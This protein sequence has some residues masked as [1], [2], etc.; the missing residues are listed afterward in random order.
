MSLGDWAKA[1]TIALLLAPL[2]LGA[3]AAAVLS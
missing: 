3:L 1:I 2:L